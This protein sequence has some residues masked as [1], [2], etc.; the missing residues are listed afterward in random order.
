[1]KFLFFKRCLIIHKKNK[2]F[3]IIGVNNIT[4]K[5]EID[6]WYQPIIKGKD[7]AFFGFLI[8]KFHNTDHYLCRYILKPGLKKSALTC[9]VNTS[10]INN[11]NKDN[12][13]S[14]FQKNIIKNI[15]FNKEYKKDTLFDN[16][17]SDEGGRFYHCQI[18]YKAIFLNEYSKINI[19]L[20]YFWVSQNQMI[21][22]IKKKNIDIEARL[23]FGCINL[24]NVK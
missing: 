4:N 15:F 3:S 8:K 1:M 20:T 23:L 16:V 12:N 13:L 11:Y 24:K 18:R 6:Q 22:M 14:Y 10:D 17:L 21:N 9:T 19:P 5:R 2:H 7:K